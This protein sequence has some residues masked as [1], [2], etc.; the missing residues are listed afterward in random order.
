[1]RKVSE[2]T[3]MSIWQGK[4]Q[5]DSAVKFSE[6][7]MSRQICHKIF[8]SQIPAIVWQKFTASLNFGNFAMHYQKL[9]QNH[10]IHINF[11]L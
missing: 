8:P 1:M 10:L 9:E 11:F 2:I 6:S 3:L 5:Q 4:V 7:Q